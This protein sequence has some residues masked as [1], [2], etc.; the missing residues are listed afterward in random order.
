[1]YDNVIFGSNARRH[2][3]TEAPEL[4]MAFRN[5][6]NAP[7]AAGGIG[8]SKKTKGKIRDWAAFVIQGVGASPMKTTGFERG[9]GSECYVEGASACWRF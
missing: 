7:L 8:K 5:L 2:I 6:E 3:G 4:S 1:V 9:G